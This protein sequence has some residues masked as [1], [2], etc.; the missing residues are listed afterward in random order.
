MSKII[1]IGCYSAFWGDTSLSAPQLVDANVDY[2]IAD[3]LAGFVVGVCVVFDLL[4]KRF[5]LLL[6]ARTN[7][8]SIFSV[9]LLIIPSLC[10]VHLLISRCAEV[11]MVILAR[12]RAANPDAGYV[13]E[14]VSL[15][16]KPLMKKIIEKKMKV[17]TNAGAWR[18]AQRLRRRCE[19]I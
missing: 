17:V 13:D 8:H 9:P 4:G 19:S 1:K 15:V 3:Y 14:F 6:R 16:W 18:S 2:L 7:F 11:T 12:A 10:V 5:S